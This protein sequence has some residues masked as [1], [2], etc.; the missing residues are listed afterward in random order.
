MTRNFLLAYSKELSKWWKIAFIVFG[1][2]FW[3]PSYSRFWFMQIRLLV[4]SHRGQN[5][6][7]SQ[8]N[9]ISLFFCIELKLCTV[10][11]LTTKFHDISTV[12]FPWQHNGLQAFSIQKIK[13]VFSPSR[14]LTSLTCSCCLFSG[15]ELIWTLH[16]TRTRKSLRLWSNK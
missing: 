7:K 4:T 2:H 9:G 15:C 6:A 12:T 8:K 11:T 10:V 16:G 13:S 5:D 3:L 1:K 14:S